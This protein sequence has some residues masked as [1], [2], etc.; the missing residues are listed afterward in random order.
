MSE[1]TKA[2]VETEHRITHWLTGKVL[3]ECKAVSLKAA[4]EAVSLK[5]AVE[6]AVERK[7]SLDGASLDGASLDGASLDGASLDGASLVGASLD[8]ASL[9][10]ASLVGAS[11]VGASLDGASLVGASLVGASLVGASLDGAS[12]DGAKIE[13]SGRTWTVKLWERLGAPSAGHFEYMAARVEC[14]GEFDWF[15]MAGC[16]R[17]LGLDAARAH[18]DPEKHSAPWKCDWVRK[19]LDDLQAFVPVRELAMK[20]AGATRPEAGFGAAR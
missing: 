11:L 19:R 3:F 13:I 6:L 7:A 9:D 14:E 18:W 16:R 15:V 5:A 12:L 17:F 4:V 20:Q 8:G 10:G 1:D 2:P